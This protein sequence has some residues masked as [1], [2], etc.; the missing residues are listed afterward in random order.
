QRY[1]IV[2]NGTAL[3]SLAL[4]DLAVFD[5]TG[6]LTLGRPSLSDLILL[7]GR[8]PTDVATAAASV[9]HG[10]GHLLA[11]TLVEFARSRGVP[12]IVPTDVVESAGAGVEGLVDGRRVMVGSRSFI[13]GK[14]GELRTSVAD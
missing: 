2:R 6:T 1:V 11:T 3:E 9:E 10:S 12:L 8:D 13:A 5:K 4:V 7:D 14:L